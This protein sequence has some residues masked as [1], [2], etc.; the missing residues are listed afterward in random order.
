MHQYPSIHSPIIYNPFSFLRSPLAHAAL[1]T[2]AGQRYQ[3][4]VFVLSEDSP[5]VAGRLQHLGTTMRQ[6]GDAP[7][8][9]AALTHAVR[10]NGLDPETWFQLGKV[11][12]E[13][14]YFI[15]DV[16]LLVLLFIY[17]FIYGVV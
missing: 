1:P 8:A 2:T 17:L 14:R 10:A 6:A 9:L 4:V 13:V 11:G 15:Y 3:L 12:K 5:D 7:A 16:L